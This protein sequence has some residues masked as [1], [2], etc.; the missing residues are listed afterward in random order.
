MPVPVMAKTLLPSVTGEGDDMFCLRI[1]VLPPLRNFFHRTVPAF[2]SIAH[3]VRSPSLASPTLRKMV[4]P[5]MMGVAPLRS[6]RGSFQAMFSSVDQRTG[7]LVSGLMPF[8]A[9]PRHWGQ[10]SANSADPQT[11]ARANARVGR[12]ITAGYRGLPAARG[13]SRSGLR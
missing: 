12:V 2:L 8:S 6:G 3:R 9:G 4:S 5:Q 11:A 13:H 10:F 7:R 1:I